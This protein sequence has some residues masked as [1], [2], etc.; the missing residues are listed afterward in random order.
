MNLTLSAKTR[1]LSQNFNDFFF[2]VLHIIEPRMNFTNDWHSSYTPPGL[3]ERN[4]FFNSLKITHCTEK[5]KQTCAL[6][7]RRLSTK[8]KN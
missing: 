1:L 6:R 8:K 7:L 2:Q 3:S 4:A 5:G